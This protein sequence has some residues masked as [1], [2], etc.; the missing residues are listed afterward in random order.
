MAAA[1]RFLVRH[2]RRP[3][4]RVL[5]RHRPRVRSRQFRL[6]AAG[7]IEGD[8]PVVH[9]VLQLAERP[10]VRYDAIELREL[11]SVVLRHQYTALARQLRTAADARSTCSTTTSRCPTPTSSASACATR[12]G[13]GTRASR[14]RASRAATASRSFS[15]TG[16]PDG[17]F[18]NS[19]W[20][21]AVQ[22][23]DSGIRRA[24]PR[25]ERHR[26]ERQFAAG[27]PPRSRTRRNRA[28]VS[29]SPT[30]IRTPRRTASSASTIRW[31][32]PTSPTI[33]S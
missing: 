13:S 12:S 3:A 33:R 9:G 30:R 29:R 6:P 8:V 27:S 26:V 5:R 28:G 10:A 15:A 16:K 22:C 32:N 31:M 23:P 21:L 4:A 17:T 19:Q 24:D 2:E 7:G 11:G 25:Q 14:C 1:A 20:Q 18:F